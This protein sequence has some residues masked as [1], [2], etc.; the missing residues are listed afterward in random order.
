MNE[1]Y[2]KSAQIKINWKGFPIS[3]L[4]NLNINFQGKEPATT[5]NN[6]SK[7]VYDTNLGYVNQISYFFNELNLNEVYYTEEE[8][9]QKFNQHLSK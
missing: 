2:P 7:F 1:E 9:I 8:F 5:I 3:E 4:D 6:L